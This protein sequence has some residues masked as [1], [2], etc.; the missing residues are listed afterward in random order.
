MK[1]RIITAHEEQHTN[2]NGINNVLKFVGIITNIDPNYNRIDSF[3]YIFNE[4]NNNYIF[5]N[6][7][8][9]LID[10]M[11]YGDKKVK[12]AYMKEKE[13][14]EFYDNGIEGEFNDYLNWDV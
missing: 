11:L 12:R 8:I 4:N 1:T 6:T 9:D 2:V 10:Y 13:F 14:D 7:I 5:F 3:C